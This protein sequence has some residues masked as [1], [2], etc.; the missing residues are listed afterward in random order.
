[1]ESHHADHQHVCSNKHAANNT[2]LPQQEPNEHDR[3]RRTDLRSLEQIVLRIPIQ[4]RVAFL[5]AQMERNKR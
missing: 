3:E 1:M 2:K 4:N 5:E